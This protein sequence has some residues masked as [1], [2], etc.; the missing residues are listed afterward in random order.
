MS[1]IALVAAAALSTVVAL[2]MP[3]ASRADIGACEV[4]A[5]TPYVNNGGLIANVGVICGV[6]H[7]WVDLQAQLQRQTNTGWERVD[8]F[9]VRLNN[10]SGFGRY[11]LKSCPILGYYY[12]TAGYACWPNGTPWATCT[13]WKYS[14]A[15]FI[16]C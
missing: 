10:T 16:Y 7:Q 12:R 13:G 15:R 11:F 9:D 6:Q 1:R 5:N 4:Q 14:T 8:Y 3:A 2:A